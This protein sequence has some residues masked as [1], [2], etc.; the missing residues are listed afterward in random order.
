[1][2]LYWN[3]TDSSSPEVEAHRAS[4]KKSMKPPTRHEISEILFGAELGQ[5]YGRLIKSFINASAGRLDAPPIVLD[6]G[7]NDGKWTRA[8][9]SYAPPRVRGSMLVDM[10][11]P[12]PHFRHLLDALVARNPNWRFW[13]VAAWTE[14]AMLNLSISVNS[15]STSLVRANAL[16][17][18]RSPTVRVNAV[19]VAELIGMAETRRASQAYT[20]QARRLQR[21][22]LYTCI[23]P[24]LLHTRSSH[25]PPIPASHAVH[26]HMAHVA[27]AWRRHK[28]R[29]ASC[30][31]KARRGGCRVHTPTAP[32][33]H[34]YVCLTIRPP[35]V[36]A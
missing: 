24:I 5:E 15:Q 36:V 12:Q 6:I 7:C 11:E 4:C 25:N 22:S 21:L 9:H 16:R 1:M 32:A 30:P 19:D 10:V 34:W 23:C 13:P 17:F 8:L 35:C 20:V 26:M 2:C 31:F 14:P 3:S 29:P 33:R 28:P 18:G 27:G